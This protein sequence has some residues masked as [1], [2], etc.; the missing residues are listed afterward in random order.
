M[1]R[2]KKFNTQDVV[3]DMSM[4]FIK[5][6]YEGTS[7]DDLVKE[8]GLLRGSLYSE[9]G[10]KRGMFVAALMKNIEDDKESEITLNLAIIA[11]ME[12][13]T[14]DN[15][16]KQIICNWENQIGSAILKNSQTLGDTR[17]GK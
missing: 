9:F 7:L 12:L 13:T 4:I 5:Y 2:N 11:M 10:S 16:V 6:G 17:D 14:H 15:E 1:G 3:T 8:T